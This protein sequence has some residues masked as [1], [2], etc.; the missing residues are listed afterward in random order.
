MKRSS[1]S[2]I[3]WAE[4]GGGLEISRCMGQDSTTDITAPSMHPD[5]LVV[6]VLCV[7][8]CSSQEA[9]FTH[10]LLKLDLSDRWLRGVHVHREVSCQRLRIR[11]S[12]RRAC[13]RIR[14]RDEYVSLARS[15]FSSR[16]GN[17]RE[18]ERSRSH[19]WSA[20][21]GKKKSSWSALVTGCV[22]V[23]FWW[24]TSW[25]AGRRFH[26]VKLIKLYGRLW[27]RNRWK[28]K[29]G[30]RTWQGESYDG[31]GDVVYRDREEQ[32]EGDGT[33]HEED[34]DEATRGST[35]RGRGRQQDGRRRGAPHRRRANTSAWTWN[36]VHART[37]VY[38]RKWSQPSSWPRF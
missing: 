31:G 20:S 15:P 21:K 32:G 18:E 4:L 3:G 5:I 33:D 26:M 9:F 35:S 10:S 1:V 37:P 29:A 16:Y 38:S 23:S 14:D 34:D 13:R 24:L 17:V 7:W 19:R 12:E 22:F 27:S 6:P 8:F 2:S 30:R 36:E 11:A 25:I 28:W